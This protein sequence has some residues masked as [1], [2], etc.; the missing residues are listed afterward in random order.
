MDDRMVHPLGAACS[1]LFV[2]GHTPQRFGRALDSEADAVILDLEDAVAPR[3]KPAARA[4]VVAWLAGL[5][6]QG[7]AR[8]LVRINATD[9]RAD[10]LADLDALQALGL[11]APAGIVVPKAASAEV[12]AGLSARLPDTWLM[13]LVESAHGWAALDALACA[14]RVLRLAFGHL[15]FQLD[16]DMSCGP[17]Q[18]ELLPVRLAIVAASRRAGLAAPVDSVTADVLDDALID[19]D[20]RRAR[21]L[22]FGGRLCIHPRQASRIRAG[23]LPREDEVAW[24]NRVL[25]ANRAAGGEVFQ[26]DGR[27]VDTPVLRKAE[28]ILRSVRA[29]R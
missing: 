12:L 17:E 1:F 7:R 5:P 18:L 21:S 14:P 10:H 20:T 3:D 2:P 8:T 13:P 16:M 19:A 28:R 23:F 4:H 24:A 11:A 29:P 6:P 9:A 27:M 22:G 15:D 25:A 26:L